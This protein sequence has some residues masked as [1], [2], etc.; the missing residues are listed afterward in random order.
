MP[1]STELISQFVKITNDKTEI[2]KESIVYGTIKEKDGRLWVQIDGSEL[3]TPVDSTADMKDGERVTVMIKN[4][5]ATVTGNITSPSASS[6][7]V[8]DIS[9]EVKDAADQISEFEILIADRV[10]TEQLNAEKARIDTLV[11]ENATIKGKVTVNEADIVSLK[12][13]DA[14]F[15]EK[16]TTNEADIKYLKA[17]M[18]GADFVDANFVT[19]EE[20][21]ATNAKVH[22]LEATYAD[23]AKQTTDDLTAK[24]ATIDKLDAKKLDADVAEA[25]YAKVATLDAE[26]GKIANLQSEVG[27]IKT[28]I[29]GSATGDT[30]HSSFANAVIAQLGEAQIKSAMIESIAAGKITAGDIIT[31]NVRIKSEDGSLLI[32]DETIQISDD[33]RVRVQIGKD[34][35]GDYSINIWDADGNL[36]FSEGGITDSAIKDAIIRNDMISDTAN[37]SAHKL[38]IDSL[39]EEI[40][41]STKTIKST[42]V[43]L[44]DEGQTLDVAFK[45]MSETV[46]EQGSKVSTQGTQ[47]SAIQ[48][49]IASKVWKQDI[50]SAVND[51]EV[52]GRNLYV[53]K[54]SQEGFMTVGNIPL[55]AMD[56]IRQEHTSE[57][58]FV[59]SGDDYVFQ[60]WVTVDPNDVNDPNLWMAYDF[61]DSDKNILTERP[62]KRSLNTLSNGQCYD[63]FYITAPTNAAYIRVSARLYSDGLVKLERGNK[64]TDWTPAPEDIDNDIETLST[65]YSAIE[66]TVDSIST[67]VVSHESTIAKK[68]D[69][70]TVTEV[71]NKVTSLEQ[72]LSGFKTTVS[73]T[74]ATKTDLTDTNEKVETVESR[75]STAETTI[76]QQ[77]DAIALRATKTEVETAKTETIS[78]MN[79]AIQASAKGIESSVSSKY[80][81]KETVNNIEIGGRNLYVVKNAVDGYLS[82]SGDGAIT[83]AS[84]ITKEKTS[85]FIPVEPGD[86][87]MFQVWATTPETSYIWYGYQFF[88]EDKTAIDTNRPA[89]HMYD[90]AGGFY[91]ATW[92]VITVP[93]GA[94]YIRVSARMFEDGKIKVEKGN[95]ATDW[96]PA[97][98]D[99]AT[100]Q[101]VDTAQ[102]SADEANDK[103]ANA[104]TLISQLKDSI[105]ML[106]T[107]GNGT[108]LMTQTEDGWT[109]ST[110]DIQSSVNAVSEGLTSLTENVGDVSSAVDIL[111]QAVDDLGTIAEYVTITTYED[112]PCIELGEGD[113]DFKLRIT[114]T[115]MMFTEGSEVLAYFTNQSFNSKKVVIEEELQQGG[116]VWKIRS[117]G[118]LALV[119]K[120]VGE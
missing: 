100:S 2:K 74:Y 104:E 46:E 52:G 59:T 78:Q 56:P 47:I 15:E 45:S 65:Q 79:A 53:I 17:N 117:N 120:G 16:I 118:N 86:E 61:Y 21:E 107:D 41:G 28:L 64:A 49:Q 8:K 94:S 68:A 98:E 75:M 116:F 67:K 108:S 40:N 76:T 1:L 39:F 72:N 43:Y 101:E 103:A 112:E 93:T 111:Q 92:D 5:V 30:I 77:S 55:A 14:T 25:T 44:D 110:S 106:V 57:F 22:N 82:S 38:D 48:G 99:M 31:N 6:K 114:N 119:W 11:A 27:D 105:S 60:V 18:I 63:S 26:I 35:S 81:T 89:L 90:M 95:K 37:I 36:M 96:T 85:D 34:A 71:S 32:S 13:K 54:N 58:I 73:N 80:A 3:L 91:H 87:I 19:T 84:A 24:Q 7:D 69:S 23:F 12:A 115:R 33:A 29:Y 83:P 97:P 50:T 10:T 113:S 102:S 4:H 109:F 66:Q 62:A 88:G 51:L 70:S 9:Q 42:R 20:L